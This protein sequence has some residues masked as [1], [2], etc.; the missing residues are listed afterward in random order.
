MVSSAYKVFPTPVKS[1]HET[2][3]PPADPTMLVTTPTLTVLADRM[4]L[5][6]LR[7]PSGFEASKQKGQ[8]GDPSDGGTGYGVA[9]E[10]HVSGICRPIQR[11]PLATLPARQSRHADLPGQAG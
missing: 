6:S 2:P 3:V 10:I 11:C 1:H 7:L 9:G 5:P 4:I 8:N